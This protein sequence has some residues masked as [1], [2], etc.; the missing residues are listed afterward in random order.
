MLRATALA[1]GGGVLLT[2]GHIVLVSSGAPGW[3]PSWAGFGITLLPVATYWFVLFRLHRKH[4]PRVLQ[5]RSGLCRACGYP[6][7]GTDGACPECGRAYVPG[8]RIDDPAEL[9]RVQAG[10]WASHTPVVR[11]AVLRL[12]IAVLIASVACVAAIGCLPLVPMPRTWTREATILARIGA[13]AVVCM[14]PIV[15]FL[16]GYGRV[17]RACRAEA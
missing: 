15:V 1:V 17:R 8:D 10:P 7:E 12:C 16:I 4:G 5:E 14:L 3:Y 13:G 2:V 9:A 11:R 6:L